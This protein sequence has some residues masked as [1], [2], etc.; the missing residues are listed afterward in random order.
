MLKKGLHNE[1][2]PSILSD[3]SVMKNVIPEYSVSHLNS[4]CEIC[5]N[6]ANFGAVLLI[7]SRPHL[8]YYYHNFST[9]VH[10]GLHQVLVDS[11][12]FKLYPIFNLRTGQI[13]LE[14]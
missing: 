12:N 8:H 11:V 10:Y 13:S 3:D 9:V 7:S 1:Y 14:R 4:F 6:S 2:I 5:P